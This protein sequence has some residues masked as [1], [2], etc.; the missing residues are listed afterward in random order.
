MAVFLYTIFIYPVYMFVEL[1]FFLANMVTN[2]NTG[3]SIIVLSLAVNI[4]CLPIYLV[5]EKW[6]EKERAMQKKLKPKITDIKAVFSGDERYMMLS[7]YYRQNHYHPLY[8]LRS[9][10]PLLI[11]IPFFIAAYSF[12]LHLPVLRNTSFLFLHDL[13]AQDGLLKIGNISINLLPILMTLINIAASAVYAYELEF[14]DKLQLY[15]SAA[16]FLVLLYSSPSGLA[17][18]WTLNNLF[19]LV[20]NVFYKVPV[21]K[22][23]W[24]GIGVA[25]L[26]ASAVTT[27][28]LALPFKATLTLLIFTAVVAAIPHVKKVRISME[29]KGGFSVLENDKIR[30]MIFFLSTST[31]LLL[32]ALVIPIT[33]MASSP[34]EF[35]DIEGIKTPFGILYYTVTQCLGWALWLGALYKLFDKPQVQ[36]YF[37]YFGCIILIVSLLDVYFFMGNE[38][39]ISSFL[40]FEDTK[41]FQASYTAFTVNLLAIAIGIAAMTMLLRSKA[42]RTLMIPMLK[43]IMAAC[44]VLSIISGITIHKEL[45]RTT[46]SNTVAAAPE[47]QPDKAYKVTKTGKNIFIFMLDRSMNFFIDPIF[48]Y[49][50]P[51]KEEYTGF[52]VFKNTIAYGSHTNM[53]APSLFGGYEYTPENINKRSTE[54]LVDKH[55]EA[56]SVL[57]KLFSENGWNVSF[58]DPS[59]LNYTWNQDLSVFDKYNMTAENIDFTGKYTASFFYERSITDGSQNTEQSTPIISG[60]RRNMLMFS[61]LR[62][63]PHAAQNVFYANG[64]YAS[65]N[66]GPLLRYSFFN[67]YSALENLEKEV[68]F[69]DSGDCINIIV[70]NATHEPLDTDNVKFIKRDELLPMAKSYCR[71]QSTEEHFYA[72]YLAHESCA[73]FF[74]FLKDNNC[75]DNSR[76]IIVGDHGYYGIQTLGMDFMQNFKGSGI[77]PTKLMPLLMMKDFNAEGELKKNYDFMTLADVPILAT[78]GLPSELQKNPFSGI[79]FK[80]T[81]DKRVVKSMYSGD[82]QA[83]HQ[84]RRSQFKKIGTQ[85]MFI[86][87]NVYDPACWSKTGFEEK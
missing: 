57:P 54:L 78:D 62:L 13:S 66:P 68:E 74:K 5:A 65:V 18:Y 72:N 51:V 47:K 14:K 52:T 27:L 86:K 17:F 87:D 48:E 39:T 60:I 63:L 73:K 84:V 55:N 7:T 12:L 25:G 33:M 44:I 19:S 9:L 34:T 80:Q 61:I 10:F 16:I 81:Q 82:W 46:G 22:K 1:I 3:L 50:K 8:A 35:C 45:H 70:N 29:K 24:Y 11:Q 26:A 71:N 30:F 64:K 76:I 69:V 49:C 21:S 77:D 6:Q 59:W 20:K 53:S 75:Y 67:A 28:A 41:R 32:L 15:I 43:I 2:G 37:A 36:K 38:G 85:W 31:V 56:L 58:T 79:P 40:T 4:I 83:D 42:A 23:V